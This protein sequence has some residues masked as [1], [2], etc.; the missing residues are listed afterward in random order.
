MERV[1]EEIAGEGFHIDDDVGKVSL[2]GAGMKSHPGVAAGMFAALAAE[3]I[4]I[5]MISTSTIRV[6]CVVRAHD[7]ERAVR[8]IHN[9]FELTETSSVRQEH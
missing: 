6:S 2:V 1:R 7:A 9:R 3:G 8:A 4:N 5:E